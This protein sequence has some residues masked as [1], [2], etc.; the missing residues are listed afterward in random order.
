MLLGMWTF[1]V[2]CYVFLYLFISGFSA[3]KKAGLTAP[4][5]KALH[6]EGIGST[7]F[8]ALAQKNVSMLT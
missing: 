4:E 1:Q 3:L 8:S 7:D 6:R 5:E 2:F